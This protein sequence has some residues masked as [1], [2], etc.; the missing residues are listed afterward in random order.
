MDPRDPRDDPPQI[1]GAG[2]ARGPA[3]HTPHPGDAPADPGTGTPPDTAPAGTGTPSREDPVL[4]ALLHVLDAAPEP[5]RRPYL[6]QRLMR[7]AKGW[8]ERLPDAITAGLVR[9]D[10][11][12][13][14]PKGGQP[15]KLYSL[16]GEGRQALAR[17]T[18][19]GTPGT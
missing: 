16:T 14:G 4:A 2:Y 7:T 13:S 6:N 5:V 8:H 19:P 18:G 1:S 3:P 10:R 17:I 12:K 11:A 9:V 15:A